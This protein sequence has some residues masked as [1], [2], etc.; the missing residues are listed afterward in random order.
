ME[1]MKKEKYGAIDIVKFLFAILIVCAHYIS[2]Y[3]DGRINKFIE[4]A[5]SL[6]IIVVPF[7]FVCSGFLLF[8]KVLSKP[9]EYEAGKNLIKNYIKRIFS[10]ILDGHAYMFPSRLS[11]G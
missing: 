9:S 3:A 11:H 7:F 1:T 4:Y 2:E 8:T 6:Y 10:C 5:S